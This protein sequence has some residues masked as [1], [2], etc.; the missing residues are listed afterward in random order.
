MNFK[1]YST[2]SHYKVHKLVRFKKLT[3]FK[4]LIEVSN[5]N[6]TTKVLFF[7]KCNIKFQKTES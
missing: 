7:F 4:N 5:T 3:I 2:K 6:E 1:K